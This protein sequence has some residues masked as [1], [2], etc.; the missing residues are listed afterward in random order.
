MHVAIT[1]GIRKGAKYVLKVAEL[2]KNNPEFHFYLIG[3]QHNDMSCGH[4]ITGNFFNN[5]THLGPVLDQVELAKYMRSSDVLIFPSESDYCPNTV[6]EA[7]ASGLPV[8]YH[9]S[10]GTPELVRRDKYLGGVPMTPENDIQPLHVLIE[11][12]ADFRRDAL[13]LTEKYFD[14]EIAGGQYLDLFKK[15]LES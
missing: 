8:W 1:A 10:G 15:L 3:N 14:S 9:N 7:M 4:L 12:L 2:L 11:N 6:L 5:V 13:S